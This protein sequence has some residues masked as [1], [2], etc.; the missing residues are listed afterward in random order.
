MPKSHQQHQAQDAMST[1]NKFR[2]EDE[3]ILTED[4]QHF[5]GSE[6]EK[7]HETQSEKE[8]VAEQDK[9]NDKHNE[10]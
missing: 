9:H 7:R 1:D 4:K 5:Q 8:F 6:K 10:E 2:P 3:S